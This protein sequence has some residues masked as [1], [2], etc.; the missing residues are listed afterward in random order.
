MGPTC[1]FQMFPVSA[2]PFSGRR[3]SVCPP[4]PPFH[5][6]AVLFLNS[7]RCP[8]KGFCVFWVEFSHSYECVC[9]YSSPFTPRALLTV[10]LFLPSCF[11]HS[12]S[13]CPSLFLKTTIIYFQLIKQKSK[14]LIQSYKNIFLKNELSVE[15]LSI[16]MFPTHSF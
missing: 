7:P 1:F 4:N 3:L 12:Y 8:H 9:A 5:F 16:K 15:K 13:S 6:A 2:L 10:P 14:T 11:S